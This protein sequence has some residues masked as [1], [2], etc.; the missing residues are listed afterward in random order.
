MIALVGLLVS[1]MLG[2]LG[3]FNWF[4]DLFSHFRAQ[5]LLLGLL[6]VIPAFLLKSRDL[7][8]AS[9]LIILI[10][11]VFVLP[12]YGQR[13]SIQNTGGIKVLS[14]NV[15]HDG[16]SANTLSTMVR[17]NEAD[18]LIL[19]EVGKDTVFRV[20]DELGYKAHFAARRQRDTF[21]VGMLS[22]L[23]NFEMETKDFG[24][25]DLLSIEA[26]FKG[27]DDKV[28]TLI[29]AHTFLPLTADGSLLRNRQLRAIAEYAGS[30]DCFITMGDLN[31]TP[32]SPIFSEVLKT[33]GLRDSRVG[34]GIHQSWPTFLPSFMRIPIDH[35]L[36][37]SN[38][39][40]TFRGVLDSVGSDH[41]PLFINLQK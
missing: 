19:A 29:A 2:F 30:K 39:D 1:T 28:C 27:T 31:I 23:P 6:F 22:R 35:A 4:L 3:G 7:V 5:Y 16:V 38:I 13:T 20:G 37:S 21:G 15:N 17:D 10:N 33:G 25:D 41:L 32:W 34:F 36:V 18:V 14:F 11:G 24:G 9:L 26:T 12:V 8:L 40:I